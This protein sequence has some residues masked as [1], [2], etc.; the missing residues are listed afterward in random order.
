MLRGIA[1]GRAD[2]AQQ[3]LG[4]QHADDVF[5]LLA[6]QRDAGVLR[7]QHLA[8]QILRRQIGVHRH[9]LGAMDHHVGN[10]AVRR[11]GTHSEYTRPGRTGI[12]PCFGGRF[13]QTPSI[14][15]SLRISYCGSFA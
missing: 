12:V 10:L 14:S 3:I 6:P 9:H 1:V 11:N 13:D 7:G 2:R 15:T 5:R 4:V 8:H